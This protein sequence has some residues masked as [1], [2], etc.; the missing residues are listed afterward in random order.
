MMTEAV[1]L[2]DCRLISLLLIDF[3]LEIGPVLLLGA[4]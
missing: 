1:T 2:S 3:G 4:A